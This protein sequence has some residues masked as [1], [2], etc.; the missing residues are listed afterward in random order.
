VT[1]AE[2]NREGIADAIKAMMAA[3]EK[4][5]W[6]GA[7][8]EFAMAQSLA[9]DDSGEKAEG[10]KGGMKDEGKGKGLLVAVLGEKKK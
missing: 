1:K 3:C 4:E 5:D 8:D 10:D 9:D 2:E 6:D 7:A